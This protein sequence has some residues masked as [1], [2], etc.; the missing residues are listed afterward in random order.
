MID[1]PLN[2]LSVKRGSALPH[3]K[4]SEDQV[5]EIRIMNENKRRI[6]RDLEDRF[7]AKGLAK[8][9]NVHTRTI[10]RVLAG[11]NWSHIS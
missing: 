6:V 11:E 7:G 4:L 9:Y 1:S 5:R 10:E 8:A 2:R 3:A